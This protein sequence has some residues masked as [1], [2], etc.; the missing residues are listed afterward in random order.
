MRRYREMK[1]VVT[2]ALVLVAG[3]ALATTPTA[4]LEGHGQP[5]PAYNT[6]QIIKW[7]QAPWIDGNAFASQ[8]APNYP[9]WAESAD[10]FEC[11]DGEPI[12][13]V[14]WWGVYYNGEYY[15]P[16]FFII[17]FYDNIPG[18]PSMPGQLL[19]QIECWDYHEEWDEYYLQYKYW[20]EL[21]YPFEQTM[22]EIYWLSIVAV[23]NFPPQW[24]WCE[25]RPEDYWMD[26]GVMDFALAGVPR[27]TTLEEAT[28]T[29]AEL[30]FVL[31]GFGALPVEQTTWGSIKA[32]YH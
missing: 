23:L 17:S 27:W 30:A 19:Y 6:D 12:I 18:P 16:D 11:I 28:G 3:V 24:G 13:K 8:Y 20:Q 1:Y 9:F 14:E 29:W 10:D 15:P 22:G 32:L 5:S 31:G 21:P 7:V 2:I 4:Y 25:C 26:C